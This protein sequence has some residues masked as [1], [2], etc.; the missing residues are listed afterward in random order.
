ML[1][2]IPA[3]HSG[4]PRNSSNSQTRAS[5][6]VTGKLPNDTK[7]Q[8]NQ[9]LRKKICGTWDRPVCSFFSISVLPNVTLC[10]VGR[11]QP[12]ILNE[13]IRVTGNVSNNL[14]PRQWHTWY[15]NT[16]FAC[17]TSTPIQKNVWGYEG[18]KPDYDGSQRSAKRSMGPLAR[19]AGNEGAGLLHHVTT[20]LC[21]KIVYRE[22]KCL[23]S[24]SQKSCRYCAFRLRNPFF[25]WPI[26]MGGVLGA[27]PCVRSERK[28]DVLVDLLG[29]LY[30][31]F[32]GTLWVD[33]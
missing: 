28:P 31:H 33:L 20:R 25:D 6:A 22:K 29:I 11:F 1:L 21:H 14:N 13:H 2:E 30:G 17:K 27:P 9:L 19:W 26:G 16:W 5:K 23:F 15:I 4:N 7:I 3:R 10:H 18:Q 12:F 8:K 32:D 24:S